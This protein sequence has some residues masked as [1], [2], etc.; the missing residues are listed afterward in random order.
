MI[1]DA[2]ERRASAGIASSRPRKGYE[3][4]FCIIVQNPLPIDPGA[5]RIARIGGVPIRYTDVSRRDRR[6]QVARKCALRGRR[7]ART[8]SIGISI[9]M[10]DVLERRSRAS[11][12]GGHA[13]AR[14]FG[15]R[16]RAE[17]GPAPRRSRSFE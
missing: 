16:T 11:I 10:D 9:R 15:E 14:A 3:K 13:I 5:S 17:S 7:C 8:A 1:H 4:F 6:D 12:R 2:R